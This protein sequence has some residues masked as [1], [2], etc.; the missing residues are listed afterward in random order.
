MQVLDI[1]QRALM[2][3]EM[4]IKAYNPGTWLRANL[5]PKAKSP[6]AKSPKDEL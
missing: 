6:K 4:W 1:L 2:H 5:P 3:A